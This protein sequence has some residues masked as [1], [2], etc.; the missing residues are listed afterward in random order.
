MIE[1]AALA[2]GPPE[3]P[4]S[5]TAGRQF[6]PFGLFETN[7][8]SDPLTLELGELNEISAQFE[9]SSGGI[10]GTIF[11]FDGDN[12]KVG[13]RGRPG[14]GAAI[15]F[16][17]ERE[18]S[19]FALDLAFISDIGDTGKLQEVI[20]GTLGS[21]NVA[22][23]VPGW[24]ASARLRY[25]NLSLLGEYLA[26]L[27]RFGVD[28]VEFAGRGAKPSSWLV[29]AAYDFGLAGKDATVAAGYQGLAEALAL[30][31]PTR[32]FLAGLSV[33]MTETLALAIEWSYDDFARKD[34]GSGERANIFKIQVATEF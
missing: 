4:W 15:G 29:E 19:E 6:L 27:K 31:L 34:G 2:L 17:L 1:V 10:H 30:E 9:L 5:F 26:S 14:C 3:G 21:N 23:H 20:S 22:D 25:E 11:G 13:D 16:S 8:I 33:A 7:L 12:E 32:R 18:E 24:T 28:E